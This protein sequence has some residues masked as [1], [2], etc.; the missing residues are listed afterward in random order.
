MKN[1]S[2]HTQAIHFGAFELDLRAGELRKQGA[3]IRLQ[4]QPFQILA[5]L[6]ERPGQVVT[7]EELRNKLWPTDT[8]VDFDHGLNKAINKLREALGDSAESP[9]FIETL[10]KRGYRFLEST[11]TRAPEASIAVLPFLNLSADP[12]NEFFCDGTT[13]EIISALAHIKNLHVVA[14][15][16]SFSFKGKHVDLRTVGQ[17]LNVQ[18]VLEGSVR[19]SGDRLRITTQLVNTTDGYHLWSERYDREMKDVFAIQEEIANSIVQHL[20][21]TLDTDQQR[22]FRAGTA[23]LDAFKFYTRGR[24]LF[25]QR[26]AR[27]LPA[28]ECF[29]KAVA[30]DPKY[31]L[32]WSGLADAYNMVA[33]YGLARPEA[34]LPHAKDAA[35]QAIT[36]DASLA[37]AHTSLAMSH[38]LHDW[39]RPSAGREFLRALELK[40]QNSL[41]RSWY[42][43]YYLQWATGRFEEG[44]AQT[45]QAV[46]IDPRSAW[47]RAMQAFTY[48]TV[49]AERSL[50]TALQTLQIDP[51]S[52][53][54]RWAQ[55]TA[56][57]LQGRFAE[58][59]EV[60]ESA[61]TM[62]GRPLWMM[63]SLAR[64]YAHL[65]KRS[66]SEALYTE[67]RWRAKREYV[68]PLFLALAA[69]AAG[70]E[71]EAIRL[72]QE[73]H[74]IGD[75]TLLGG[76]Y[77]PD[78]CEM[79]QDAR[80]QE[81]L[82]NRGWT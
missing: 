3:K 79:R 17:Q 44:L 34:C 40:P 12:E 35:Q 38:L 67:L 47:D 69:Y 72:E 77:W 78:F 30:L 70:E 1:I 20:E 64:T 36:L 60:G 59:A 73:A 16:S 31:G 56:L 63:A 41:A 24:S 43:L 4:E 46:Q 5:M 49:D 82:R 53:L 32:A 80:F 68:A 14:R 37:E 10:A 48:L 29:R 25:F 21:I 55:M 22:L 28:V 61:L 71:D 2:S 11:A 6:L 75:P 62:I 7:R 27:L 58:A 13:E 66:D 8:F 26:G 42:G 9:R 50:E 57:N 39:D 45:T 33:F 81:I 65:G 51:D 54:G 18:T 74:K 15:T 76:K 23:V 52:F 19:R